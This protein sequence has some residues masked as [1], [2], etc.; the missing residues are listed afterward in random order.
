M[1]ALYD[2]SA[3]EKESVLSPQIELKW[4]ALVK[5][6]IGEQ[7]F[8]GCVIY[9]AKD[10]K[11]LFY[12]PFGRYTYDSDSK[13]VNLDTIYDL[14]S[15]TKVSASVPMVM[16]LWEKGKIRLDMRVVDLIPEFSE[17]EKSRITVENLITHSSGL[18]SWVPFYETCSSFDEVMNAIMKTPLAN[19]VETKTEYSDLNMVLVSK[20][21][22]LLYGEPIDRA[23]K[24][25]I[26]GPLGMVDTMY[27]PGPE[28]KHRIAPTEIDPW[29]DRLLQGEVHDENAYAMGGVSGHAGLFSTAIDLGRYCQCLLNGGQLDGVRIFEPET[30]EFFSKRP[31]RLFP[32]SYAL[33]WVAP[34]YRREGKP[35]FSPGS[36][37]HTGYTG[38]CIWMDRVRNT[39]TV[40]LSNRVY[41]S[42]RHLKIG[43][44]R[45]EFMEMIFSDMFPEG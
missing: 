6:Y 26:H 35:I 4:G 44:F 23:A 36:I 11:P 25:E 45:N 20:I 18:P 33:G 43:A 9:V 32:G 21:I 38:T 12:R 39:Q 34:S 22:H 2:E 19:P 17:G 7:A 8:P 37:G 27:R 28:L 14:A 5:K 13:P 31:A 24:K 3:I 10:G 16:K 15:V 41:P 42:R 1:R 40:I 29:R 30:I